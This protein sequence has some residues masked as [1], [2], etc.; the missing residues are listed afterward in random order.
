MITISL[1]SKHIHY[2]YLA[3][4][5][6]KC[7]RLPSIV[8]AIKNLPIFQFPNIVCLLIRS[9]TEL[10]HFS[11]IVSIYTYSVSPVFKQL[12][13]S[14][15]ITSYN[16]YETGICADNSYWLYFILI[17]FFTFLKPK[18]QV[19]TAKKREYGLYIQYKLAW[20]TSLEY[21]YFDIFII[22]W[23]KQNRKR[24]TICHLNQL[25]LGSLRASSHNFITEGE[26]GGSYR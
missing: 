15:F 19:H 13:N 9:F 20:Q 16:N 7:K 2:T 25:S 8:A 5:Y 26:T 6:A 4:T 24:K 3:N 14:Q 22:Y 1:L 17:F 12:N 18:D 23:L 10:Q 11:C 21:N